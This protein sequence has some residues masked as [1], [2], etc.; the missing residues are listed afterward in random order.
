MWLTPL[1]SPTMV[2]SAVLK[3]V[4]SSEASSI[5]T[6]RP[7]KMSRI[8]RLVGC[9]CGSTSVIEFFYYLPGER[10]G[11]DFDLGGGGL[12]GVRD[13]FSDRDTHRSSAEG[14]D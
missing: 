8:E 5:V 14:K 1:S 9:G 7:A 11:S 10:D 2:G 12:A 3:M 13:F 6:I 4:L